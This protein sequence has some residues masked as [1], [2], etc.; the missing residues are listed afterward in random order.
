MQILYRVADHYIYLFGGSTGLDG[1]YKVDT[2]YRSNR[3]VESISPTNIP[4]KIAIAPTV[5]P[6]TDA[7][8]TATTSHDHLM[9]PTFNHSFFLMSEFEYNYT[10]DSTRGKC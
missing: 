9:E 6:P 3:L 7:P 1:N 8:T 5:S 4:T 2:I 10:N